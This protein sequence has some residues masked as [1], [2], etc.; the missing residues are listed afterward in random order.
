[1]LQ[2]K[3]EL[4]IALNEAFDEARH[5]LRINTDEELAKRVGVSPKM[6]SEWRNGKW[7]PADAGLIAVLVTGLKSLIGSE[8][9][10]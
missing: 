7:S 6:I 4:V 3:P 1:M 10:L 8:V 9:L 5:L 2:K